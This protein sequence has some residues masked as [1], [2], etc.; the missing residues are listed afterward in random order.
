[1]EPSKSSRR[2]APKRPLSA[3]SGGA[4]WRR[5]GICAGVAL[6]VVAGGGPEV[7]GPASPASASAATWYAYANGEARSP[8]SCPETSN[9]SEQCTLSEALSKASAGSSIDLASSGRAG[10]YVGNWTVSTPGTTSSAP[11]LIRPAAGVSQPTL[12]GNRGEPAGCGTAT[13]DGPVLTIGPKVHVDIEGVTIRHADNT[14]ATGLGGGIENIHGGFVRVSRSTFLD[15]YADAN[16]G[17]I[18]NAD[19]TGTGTLIVSGSTFLGNYAENDDGGAIANA[20]VDGH[21]TVIVSSSTFSGNSAINGDGGAIDNGDTRGNGR[22]VVSASRFLGNVAGRAG[23]IDNADNARGTLSVSASTFSGN[24]SALAD[25][26]AIDNADWGGTGTLTVSGS[27]FSGN[28]TIGDGG[29]IDN[30]DNVATSRGTLIVSSSTFSGNIADVHGGAI[31]NADFGGRGLAAVSASTFSGN[32]ANNI[33]ANNGSPGG[34][35]IA[36]G[37]NSTMWVVADIFNGPCLRAGGTW[38][39]EGYNVGSNGSCLGRA[40]GDVGHGANRLGPLAYH[41]GPT[42][43]ILPLKGNPA[44]DAVPYPTTVTLYRRPV[45]LCPSTDQRGTR[46][47]SRRSCAAGAVQLPG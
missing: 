41:G 11:L 34:G 17:A 39:D 36:T 38:E 32:S 35:V 24:V 33:Y 2:R 14:T 8:T 22:L 16:G 47:A 3:R 25:A 4:A 42:M 46:T 43:T 1:V 12:G 10:V 45:G 6:L 18:D 23:A 44:I 7:A 5:R 29:A 19:I 9:A 27:T 37:T 30:A 28:K 40:R 31:D 13:C 15:D 26:G 21:G 20:D